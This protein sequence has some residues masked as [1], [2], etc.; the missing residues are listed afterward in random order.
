MARYWF[1]AGAADYTIIVGDTVTVGAVTGRQSVVVGGQQVKAYSAETGGDPYNDLLDDQGT[2]VAAV[3]S[4]DGTG[5]R[6]LGQIPPAQ[7]PDGVRWMWVS[8]AGGPRVLAL[9]RLAEEV[10]ATSALA[11]QT[12]ADLAAHSAAINPHVTGLANLSD[13]AMG[14]PASRTSGQVV[15]WD[16]ASQR[17]VMLTASQ[18]SGALLLNPPPVAGAYVGNTASPPD[19]AQGQNGNPWLKL[20][21][22]YSATDDNPDGIQLYSTSSTGQSIKTGWF[23]GNGEPRA[24]PSLPNRIA[25][26]VFEAYENRNGPSTGRF[27]EFSTNPLNSANREALFGG[28]G[29]GHATQ[30]GWMVA[31]RVLAGLLGVRAGGNYNSLTAVNFRGQKSTTGAP[32][33]GTWVAGDVVLDSAGA[34]YLCT[35]G[36]TPGTWVTGAG[37]TP[38]AAPTAYTALTLGTSM[39][40]GTKQAAS[41]LDRGADSGRLRGTLTASGAVSAGAV[42]AT[43]AATSHRPLSMATA[44]A[45]YSGGGSQ[46]QIATN[47]DITL[48][49]ALTSGQSVWLDSLTWD[50]LA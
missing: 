31:T 44:I 11:A 43:I 12:A 17:Y 7:G 4:S 33:A 21:Q 1:F 50:M 13:A 27:V 26:R 9:G 41:R 25:F 5:T 20:T 46:I 42:V 47:G 18:A 6:G 28:Y 48:G 15:G 32:T 38:T 29:T 14:T 22:P 36:G 23:N 40:H 39:G 35:V 45:R 30:P 34:V 37:G 3:T 10:A 8:A 24:A 2:A 16:A 19:P 49:S